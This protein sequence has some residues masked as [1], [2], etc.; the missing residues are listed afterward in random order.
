MFE[1]KSCGT[2]YYMYVHKL[3]FDGRFKKPSRRLYIDYLIKI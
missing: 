3:L 2:I 1:C